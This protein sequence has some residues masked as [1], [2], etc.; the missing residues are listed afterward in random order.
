[1][2]MVFSK[3]LNTQLGVNWR[4]VGKRVVY[5]ELQVLI[6]VRSMPKVKFLLS[7]KTKNKKKFL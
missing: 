4:R 7:S 5:W 6:Q 3:F 2:E 1:M